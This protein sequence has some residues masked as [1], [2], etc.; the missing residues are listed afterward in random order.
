MA[1]L[2]FGQLGRLPGLPQT[3]N[4]YAFDVVILVLILVWLLAS[5]FGGP[6]VKLRFDGVKRAALYFAAAALASWMAVRPEF[7]LNEWLAG[8]AYL[9]RWLLYFGLYLVYTD[10]RVKKLKLPLKQYLTGLALAL[11]VIGLI[12]YLVL[13]DTRWL[14]F[15]GWDDHYYRAIGSLGDPS[16]LGLMLLLGLILS[17]QWFLLITL[18]LTYSRSTYLAVVAVMIAAASFKRAWR[19]LAVGLLA[20]AVVLPLLPRPGGEGVNLLR[21]FSIEQRFDNYREG[22]ALWSRSPLLGVG[23]N[24]LR[25]VR[26]DFLSHAAAGLDNSF[27]FVA[28]TAGFIGLMAYLNLLRRLCQSGS[29][30]LKLS[31]VAIIVHS[32]FQNSLFYPLVMI[33]LW[34]LVAINPR[35]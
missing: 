22:I 3:L 16:F 14:F 29:Q 5:S 20:L 10:P 25:S 18:F 35:D 6:Q 31:L 19:M 24:M 27:I 28:A 30:I 13:P 12:Q 11:G 1:A 33:W 17:R 32:L 9:A 2:A 7:P 15:S 8:G 26:G 34:L 21:L 4:V 23:F